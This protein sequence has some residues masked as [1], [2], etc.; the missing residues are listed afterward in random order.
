MTRGAVHGTV[1]PTLCSDLGTTWCEGLSRTQLGS[2]W[3]QLL[4]LLQLAREL[5]DRQATDFT[6]GAVQRVEGRVLVRGRPAL[7]KAIGMFT[8]AL[9]DQN[10]HLIPHPSSIIVYCI[11]ITLVI[12]SDSTEGLAGFLKHG[13]M[14]GS[15][16]SKPP[17]EV[18]STNRNPQKIKNTRT[19]ARVTHEAEEL[20]RLAAEAP[21]DN[22]FVREGQVT[23]ACGFHLE[24]AFAFILLSAGPHPTPGFSE[25]AWLRGT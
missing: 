10:L 15:T 3:L 5:L 20:P 1:L 6:H 14:H 16:G 22:L 12:Q 9:Q 7:G 19:P 13:R 23:G 11:V 17:K 8:G 18:Q 24:L 25:M 21:E 4:E 2:P